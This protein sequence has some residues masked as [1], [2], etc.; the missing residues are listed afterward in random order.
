[1]VRNASA[2]IGSK[3]NSK[4]KIGPLKAELKRIE[5]ELKTV[6]SHRKQCDK[7]AAGLTKA[8]LKVEAKLVALTP[9]PAPGP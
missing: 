2:L 7:E 6:E 8:K 1:M 3:G 4:A 9:A 5:R